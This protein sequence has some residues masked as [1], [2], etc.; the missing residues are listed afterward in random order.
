MNTLA[1]SK[2]YLQPSIAEKCG[3][4]PIYD[5]LIVLSKQQNKTLFDQ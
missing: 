1:K 4:T 5:R 2:I 3:R